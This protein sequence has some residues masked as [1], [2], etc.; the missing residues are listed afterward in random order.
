MGRLHR[1]SAALPVLLLLLAARGGA[2][3]GRSGGLGAGAAGAELLDPSSAP[4]GAPGAAA[5]ADGDFPVFVESGE[6]ADA[7]K[8]EFVVYSCNTALLALTL[9]KRAVFIAMS[10]VAAAAAS[11][12]TG[13]GPIPK[14]EQ[15]LGLR[16]CI[17]ESLAQGQIAKK[18]GQ[19]TKAPPGQFWIVKG[20][21]NPYVA[22]RGGGSGRGAPVRAAFAHRSPRQARQARR[23]RHCVD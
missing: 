20:T 10:P 17:D 2:G 3:S 13:G 5:P 23:I 11:M 6:G 7:G 16:V 1:P 18:L 4:G 9:A 21:Y 14:V 8:G 15:T 22:R 12:A 19:S